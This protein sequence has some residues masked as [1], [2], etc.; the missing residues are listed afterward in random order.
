MIRVSFISIILTALA[1]ISPN[2]AIIN[3]PADYPAIQQGINAGVDGDTVLVQPGTYL[4]NLNYNGHNIVLG[5]LFLTTGD[6][7]YIEQTIIDGDSAGSVVTFINSENNSAVLTG[8]TIRNG[9]ASLGAGIHCNGS[10]PVISHNIITDNIAY[11]IQGG[12]GGGVFCYYSNLTLT[13]NVIVANYASGPIESWGGGIYCGY[14][15][16]TVRRNIIAQNLSARG[17]G[18]Y[19]LESDPV[20][21]GNIIHG[22]T[23]IWWGGGFYLDASDPIIINSVIY[24]NE[25]RW[26]EGGGIYVENNSNPVIINSILWADSAFT[27]GDEIYIEYGTPVVSYTNISGGWGGTGNMDVWPDFRDPVNND[28]HLMSTACGDQYDSPCIDVGDPLIIDSLL[29]CDAGLG[30]ELS[31]MGAYG[32][33]DS[34]VTDIYENSGPLPEGFALS[35]NYPNPFNAQTTISY[36]VPFESHFTIEIFDLLGRK[37]ETLIDREESP[38]RHTVTWNAENVSSGLYLYSIKAGDFKTTRMMS[39]IK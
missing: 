2:A 32:G 31:D 9:A 1:L 25:A 5:S 19:C 21:S 3:I 18:I 14:F 23:G 38:G 35:Q 24:G 13:D 6:E 27:E 36:V 11:D 33:G 7:S 20:F 34:V 29:S 10:D 8:F 15:A 17:G 39:L 22:N 37:V 28:F 30:T 16:P 4:E 12:Q 26:N